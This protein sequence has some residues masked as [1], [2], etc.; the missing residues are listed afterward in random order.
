MKKQKNYTDADLE[1]VMR[2]L[3]AGMHQPG[4]E[5]D[6]AADERPWED[7]HFRRGRHLRLVWTNPGTPRRRA[8]LRP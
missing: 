3:R 5:D 1:R 7:G 8:R 4:R 6:A 2:Q